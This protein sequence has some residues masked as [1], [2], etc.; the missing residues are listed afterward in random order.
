MNA[1]WRGFGGKTCELRSRGDAAWQ[2]WGGSMLRFIYIQVWGQP[3]CAAATEDIVHLSA[4]VLANENSE[5]SDI[6]SWRSHYLIPQC[7]YFTI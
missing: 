3:I 6:K 2:D 5:F 4:P 7:T 1:E